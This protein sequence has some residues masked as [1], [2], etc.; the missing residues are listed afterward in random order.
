LFLACFFDRLFVFNNLASFVLALFPVCFLEL[1]YYF[2]QLPSFVFLKGVLFFSGCS[3]FGGQR[4]LIQTLLRRYGGERGWNYGAHLFFSSGRE[5]CEKHQPENTHVGYTYPLCMSRKFSLCGR[6]QV[7]SPIG[8]ST[9][10]RGAQDRAHLPLSA[11][12]GASD[13]PLRHG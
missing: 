3:V 11:T 2:Q 5:P 6:M 10:S 1:F 12:G 8:Q 13:W 7:P 4:A 9:P